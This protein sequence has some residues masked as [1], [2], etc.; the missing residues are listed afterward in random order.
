VF[1]EVYDSPASLPGIHQWVTP[2]ADVRRLEELLGIPDRSIGAPL[3]VSGDRRDCPRCG[4]EMS[5]LDIV[6]SALEGI[7]GPAMIAQIILGARKF[8]NIEAPKAIAGV[9]CFECKAE[10]RGLRSFKCHNWAYAMPA[11]RQ[12]LG[13]KLD[14]PRRDLNVP[15]LEPLTEGQV[16]SRVDG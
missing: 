8:V 13:E 1:R 15:D 10:I 4:R 3:W 9:R 5:W 14:A 11:L 7:H 16:A 2:D 6:S 12:V